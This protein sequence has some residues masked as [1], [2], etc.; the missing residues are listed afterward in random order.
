MK[1]ENTSS[2]SFSSPDISKHG[3]V[4]KTGP[5][6]PEEDQLVIRL[7]EKNGPQKWT[8]IAKHLEGRIGKQCRER[9]HNHLNPLIRKE[10]WSE[11]EEWLLFLLHKMLGNRWAEISK[12][13]KGR[14]D[15]SIKNHWNSSM[16]KKIPDFSKYYEASLYKYG[17]FAEGHECSVACNEDSSRRKR[18]RRANSEANEQKD[19]VCPSVHQ[20]LLAEAVE[21][22]SKDFEKENEGFESPKKVGFHDKDD[23]TFDEVCLMDDS[24]YMSSPMFSPNKSP[25]PF[26]TPKLAKETKDL[27]NPTWQAISKTPP[28]VNLCNEFNFES[29]SVMLNLESPKPLNA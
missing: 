23:S 1:I 16:K 22:Y 28:Q 7:V 4:I 3:K 19:L 6:T 2:K 8:F 5:W 12:I 14:T 11:E 20:Y 21:M 9:W 24:E 13:L 26:I 15:N 29:P 18:G 10:N 25:S 17:H 27:L